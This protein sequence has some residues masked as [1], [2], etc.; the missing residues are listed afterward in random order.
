MPSTLFYTPPLPHNR[1]E[2]SKAAARKVS[3][4]K[5]D[6]DRQRILDYAL[7]VGE[8]GVTRD[9]LSKA[10]GIAIQTVCARV[11]YLVKTGELVPKRH[12]ETGRVLTRETSSGSDAEVLVHTRHARNEEHARP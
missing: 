10:L 12:P 2:T 3:R 6:S 7:E 4:Q 5:V 1:T 8:Y 11:N 9:E